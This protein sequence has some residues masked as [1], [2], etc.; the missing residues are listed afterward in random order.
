MRARTPRV[1]LAHRPTEWD[2]LLERHATPGQARFFLESR[3]RDVDDVIERHRLQDEA[4]T[5]AERAI[6]STW[7]RARIGRADL[8]A[9]LFEPDDIVVAVGQDGLVPNIAKYL[10]GQAVVGVNPDPARYEGTLVR[11]SADAI[12]DLLA[13]IAGE[14]AS[15]ETRTMV[16]A[17]L[18]DGQ[19][20]VALNEMYVG[21]RTH[22][23]SRYTITY[24]ARTER[25]SSS[26]LIVSTGTGASGWARSIS[27]QRGSDLGLPSPTENTL[28]FFVR[29]AWPSIATGV[30][31]TEGVIDQDERL[32]VTSEIEE[33]GVA[34][35]DGIEHDRLSIGWGQQLTIGVA[36]TRLRLVI[37]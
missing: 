22:Q 35:G 3:G 32:V 20:L 28:V 26:G 24:H 29:E 1:V 21:H 37:P 15:I 33:G 14:R 30:G 31:L 25:Q 8:P 2:Q 27:N 16:E 36:S 23:S 7:R 17:R 34:F 10:D 12:P 4:M 18:D 19:R 9:F 13:E 6:P 11:G 5:A